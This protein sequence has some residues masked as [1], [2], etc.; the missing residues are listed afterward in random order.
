ME[1][2]EKEVSVWPNGFLEC[3]FTPPEENSYNTKNILK[4][5]L[6]CLDLNFTKT[7]YSSPNFKV[8]NSIKKKADLLSFIYCFHSIMC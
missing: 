6:N 5:G 4:D 7:N 1:T 3:Y 2:L 8:Q